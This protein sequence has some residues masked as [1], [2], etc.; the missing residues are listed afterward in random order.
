MREKEW[1]RVRIR[2]REKIETEEFSCLLV[3]PHVLIK[4]LVLYLKLAAGKSVQVY[5][6]GSRNSVFEPTNAT[7]ISAVTHS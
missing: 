1:G 3:S 2:D 4:T 7:S 6:I 5:H